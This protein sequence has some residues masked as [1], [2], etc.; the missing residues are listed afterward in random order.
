MPITLEPKLRG[1]NSL[2]VGSSFQIE[3]RQAKEFSV[4]IE[5]DSNTAKSVK[6]E[7]HGAT[8][9]LRLD[10]GSYFDS[11]TLKAEIEMPELRELELSGASKA[12]LEGF[13]STEPLKI[14]LNGASSVSGDINAGDARVTLSGASKIDL[15]GHVDKATVIASGASHAELRDWKSESGRIVSSG[16]SS[17]HLN[18]KGRVDAVASG[19]SHV[20]VNGGGKF[21]EVE[22]SGASTA[23]TE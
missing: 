21:G 18:S 10:D 20:R 14:E 16:A 19:A 15:A 1:F 22:T 3:V 12:E 17:I 9:V 8:L 13:S 23:T 4:K 7:V 5:T 6:A 11:S 2:R